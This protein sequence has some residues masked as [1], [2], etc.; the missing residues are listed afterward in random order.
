M[1]EGD[2]ILRLAAKI[3]DRFTGRTVTSAIFRHPRLA[4]LDLT[5]RQLVGSEAN[6]KHL[7]LHWDDGRSLHV[8]LLMQ[9]RVRFSR[10]DHTE[11][12]RRRFEIGF[13]TGALVGIDVPIVHLLNTTDIDTVVG[14]L[15]PNLC[16]DL[17]IDLA[18][19]RLLALHDQPLGGALLDQRAVAG[20]GNIYAVEVPFICGISPLR[21]IG[22]VDGLEALV[23]VGTALIRTNAHLGPQNTTGK[24]LNRSDHHILST[25]T[26]RCPV[27]GDRLERLAEMATSWRRR[28]VYCPSCQHPDHGTVDDGRARKL[29]GLH[30]ARRLLSFHEQRIDYVGPTDPVTLHQTGQG[31]DSYL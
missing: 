18:V 14:H 8:H 7:F 12:W 19:S 27:C 3:H 20:F 30:P 22:T 10:Q 25:R 17:D 13:E 9:G 11:E 21:M 16:G 31:R 23:A 26:R 15:G 24:H 5:G 28:T 4:T 6:G 2:T 29:L 1:P